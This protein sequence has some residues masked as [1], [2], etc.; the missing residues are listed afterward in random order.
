MGYRL[1]WL[2]Q[3]PGS[4]TGACDKAQQ[5]RSSG[6]RVADWGRVDGQTASRL[7]VL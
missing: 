4:Q 7:N 6:N 2:A 1:K 3:H 5:R